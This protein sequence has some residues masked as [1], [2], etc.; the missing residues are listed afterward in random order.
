MALI[1][2]RAGD[3]V[4][5]RADT[6]AA[7]VGLGA[8]VAVVAGR[9]VGRLRVGAHTRRGV[10]GSGRSAERRVGEG[11]GAA[12]GADPGAA[13]VGLG[14]GVAVVA[15]RPVGRVRIRARTGRGVAGPGDMALIARRAGDRVAARADTGAAGV[16]LGARIAVVEDRPVG[17]L[18][19]GA[20]TRRGVAGSG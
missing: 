1:A 17:R 13:G 2:R 18:R 20:H 4:A 3:G 12:A 19:V 10:A 9:P 14:A 5:A 16:G 6:G 8:G 15:G 11:D 7:G